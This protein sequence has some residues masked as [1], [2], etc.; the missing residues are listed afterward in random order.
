MGLIERID[1]LRGAHGERLV[2]V[3][4]ELAR[5]LAEAL[6]CADTTALA[7]RMQELERRNDLLIAR[8]DRLLGHAR[9]SGR[10][11]EDV[12]PP[13]A[14]PPLDRSAVR[15]A[16]PKCRELARRLGHELSP[17]TIP[18]AGDATAVCQRP[19][20]GK[21]VGVSPYGVGGGPALAGRCVLPSQ[22]RTYRE[23][24]CAICGGP[25]QPSGPRS[26]YCD[27]PRCMARRERKRA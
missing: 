21:T 3:L 8:I 10:P 23:K 14:R 5:G 6:R 4:A 13:T 20:C 16:L 17:W 19:G 12:P 1:S 27:R 26:V 9:P 11:S 18:A 24:P 15:A 2:D 22:G 7:A 25:F